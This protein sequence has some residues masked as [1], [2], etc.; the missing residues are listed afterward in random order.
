LLVC[1][2]Q[3]IDSLDC[4]RAGATLLNILFARVQQRAY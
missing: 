4:L 3:L 2:G 1:S